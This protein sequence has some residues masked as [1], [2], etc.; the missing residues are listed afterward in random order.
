MP[1]V[2]LGSDGRGEAKPSCP[3]PLCQRSSLARYFIGGVADFVAPGLAPGF[4]GGVTGFEGLSARPGF[5]GLLFSGLGL[6]S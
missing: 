2:M 3:A 5:G 6:I 1:K 4:G